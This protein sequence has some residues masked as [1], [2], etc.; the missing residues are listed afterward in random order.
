MTLWNLLLA[1]QIFGIC[2][3]I[4]LPA[5]AGSVEL[6]LPL[7][8]P[9]RALAIQDCKF[10]EELVSQIFVDVVDQRDLLDLLT[11]LHAIGVPFSSVVVFDRSEVSRHSGT[12]Q[13][14]AH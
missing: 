1:P 11:D 12:E 14:P 5:S 8:T 2:L 6:D 10:G 9:R 4:H 13:C 3:G 7:A